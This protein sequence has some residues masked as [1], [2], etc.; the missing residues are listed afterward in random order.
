MTRR[1]NGMTVR[2]E[3]GS[4]LDEPRQEENESYE[5]EVG[6]PAREAVNGS[7]HE[8]HPALLRCSFIHG[9]DTRTWT[10]TDKGSDEQMKG[11]GNH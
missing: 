7:V 5:V 10:K 3:T 1:A 9:E 6:A 8:E 2:G 11:R 4:H